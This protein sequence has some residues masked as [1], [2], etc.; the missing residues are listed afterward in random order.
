MLKQTLHFATAPS[1]WGPRPM[2]TSG[3]A[4]HASRQVFDYNLFATATA[5]FGHL[6]PDFK[7]HAKRGKAT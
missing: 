1:I 5:L 2:F 6:M 3:H 4:L 7:R